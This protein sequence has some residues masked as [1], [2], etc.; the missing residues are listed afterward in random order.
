M[1]EDRPQEE[2]RSYQRKVPNHTTHI[3]GLVDREVQV[4]A[5]EY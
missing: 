5:M 4:P 3:W 2:A 1:T